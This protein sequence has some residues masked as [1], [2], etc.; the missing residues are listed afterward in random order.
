MIAQGPDVNPDNPGGSRK[1]IASAVVRAIT[2]FCHPGALPT[3]RVVGVALNDVLN[4]RSGPD[5]NTPIVNAI[6]PDGKGIRMVGGCAGQWCPVE[7]LTTKGWVNRRFLAN[8]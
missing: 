6:P 5:A 4:I 7:Y 3:Y 8:E 1:S 2:E